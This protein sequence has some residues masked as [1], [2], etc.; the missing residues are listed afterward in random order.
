M[1]KRKNINPQNAFCFLRIDF[2]SLK[3]TKNRENFVLFFD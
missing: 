2:S 1:K 3:R